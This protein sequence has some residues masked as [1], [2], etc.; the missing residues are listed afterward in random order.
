[1]EYHSKELCH[2]AA[3]SH[4]VDFMRNVTFQ[5][6]PK[7]ILKFIWLSFS[8]NQKRK[9]LNFRMWQ[10]FPSS[11]RTAA[12]TVPLGEHNSNA[13]LRAL[14]GKYRTVPQSEWRMENQKLQSLSRLQCDMFSGTASSPSQA[15]SGRRWCTIL[16]Y[17]SKDLLR[18]GWY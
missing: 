3:Y 1:M 2:Q 13:V 4:L 10:S 6:F 12:R 11:L 15:T 17:T 8:I 9:A 16:F 5:V 14:P 18:R 7:A